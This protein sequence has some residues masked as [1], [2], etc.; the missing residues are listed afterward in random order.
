MLACLTGAQ[1]G[2]ARAQHHRHDSSTS[3]TWVPALGE[4]QAPGQVANA[5]GILL[6]AL[7]PASVP[8]WCVLGTV[9]QSHLLITTPQPSRRK[10][11][12]TWVMWTLR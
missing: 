11:R 8:I 12:P 2:R 10:V 3:H 1:R 6:P 9:G 4:H 5:A 7:V